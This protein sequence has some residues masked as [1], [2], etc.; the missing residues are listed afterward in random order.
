MAIAQFPPRFR[1]GQDVPAVDPDLGVKGGTFVAIDDDKDANGSYVVATC[2]AGDLAFGVAEYDADASLGG[3]FNV[4]RPGSIARVVP[5]EALD[6]GML[7]ASDTDGK[8]VEAAAHDVILGQVMTGCASDAAF[9]E[10]ALFYTV[11][12]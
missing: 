8:A 6:A 11:T 5:G 3:R 10:I 1:S 4:V 2:G 9:A 7:V 12:A